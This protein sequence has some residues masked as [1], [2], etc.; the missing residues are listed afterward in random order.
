MPTKPQIIRGTIIAL[1][2]AHD[3]HTQ[4][5]AR[6]TV[7]LCLEAQEALKEMDAIHKAQITYLCHMLNKNDIPADEFDLIALH[8][9]HTQ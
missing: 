6:K 2:I 9:H 1:A 7:A 3:V 8:Y 5:Q 4:I